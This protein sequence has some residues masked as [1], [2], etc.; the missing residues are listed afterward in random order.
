MPMMTR[1][2]IQLDLVGYAHLYLAQLCT[3]LSVQ[4]NSGQL[5]MLLVAHD[6]CV[7]YMCNHRLGMT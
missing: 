4:L 1:Q 7:V 6:G 2:H 5:G 3:Q